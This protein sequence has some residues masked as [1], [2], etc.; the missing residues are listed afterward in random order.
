MEYQYNGILLN[1]IDTTDTYNI[2]DE[3][4]KHYNKWKMLDSYSLFILN[5]TTG[6]TIATES[7]SVPAWDQGD[8]GE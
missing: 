8:G 6:K 4:Q 3:S 7:R 1:N 2:M 5:F